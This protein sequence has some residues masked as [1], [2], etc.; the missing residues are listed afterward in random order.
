MSRTETVYND[1]IVL[2]IFLLVP[3]VMLIVGYFI[4]PCSS[5]PAEQPLV[6]IPLFL[7]LALLGSGFLLKDKKMGSKLKISGWL[8]FSFFWAL[9]PC[10]L[11]A[12]EG[13]DVFNAV[14]CIIG[15]YTLIYMAY[16]EW[17]S[18]KTDEY[19]SCLNWIA[20]GSFLAGIIY[21]TIDSGLFPD[22]RNGLIRLVASHSNALL[23]ILGMDA[24]RHGSTIV[25]NG[26]AVNIIFACTAIQAMVLF[27]GMIGALSKV[28]FTRKITAIAVTVI[29]MYFLNLV[30]NASVIFLVGGN[31]T[32]FYIAHNVL[33]KAGALITL[34]ALLFLTFKIVPE[35]YDEILCIF[36]LPKRKGPVENFFSKCLGKTKK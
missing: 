26:T 36:D 19:T 16:Q 24:V 34:I 4:Y 31:I 1:N 9:L 28:G 15:V 14:V 2:F 12:S 3:T 11:Y 29:P 8:M 13:G 23:N 18:I 5:P 20:G 25:Y 22:L 21:F 33:A 17:L 27:I 6:F 10:F 30:R 32:S 35:L 7:G